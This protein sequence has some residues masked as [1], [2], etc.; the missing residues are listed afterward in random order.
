MRFRK[1]N[2][3]KVDLLTV[4]MLDY[5]MDRMFLIELQHGLR[6]L[7]KDSIANDVLLGAYNRETVSR[8][9]SDIRHD[10]PG[11]KTF[12]IACAIY[13]RDCYEVNPLYKQRRLITPQEVRICRNLLESYGVL[14]LE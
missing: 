8:A 10:I 12:A 5:A 14:L 13:L 1:N 9:N 11:H 2:E 4:N 7:S 3:Y 6:H